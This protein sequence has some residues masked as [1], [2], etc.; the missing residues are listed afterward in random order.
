MVTAQVQRVSR[1]R[2]LN[3]DLKN[4]SQQNRTSLA[5]QKFYS[6]WGIFPISKATEALNWCGLVLVNS[7]DLV[8]L[9]E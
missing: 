5:K 7:I 1:S 2:S 4:L 8:V 3:L 6:R 9:I